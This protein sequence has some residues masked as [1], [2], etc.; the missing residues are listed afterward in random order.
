VIGFIIGLVLM[1]LVLG[2]LARLLVPGRDPMS[3]GGTILLGIVG[4]II[5]GVVGR[6]IFH[7]NGGSFLLALVATIAV[8]LVF[9]RTRT[10]GGRGTL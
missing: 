1:G 10:A 3:V 8:L 5:G 9:R 7:N 4:S 2:A 6:A